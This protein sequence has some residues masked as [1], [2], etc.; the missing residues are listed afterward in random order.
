MFIGI[1][2][3]Y[4]A[5]LMVILD[6]FSLYVYLIPS[7]VCALIIGVSW[8]YFGKL[9]KKSFI[10][11]NLLPGL[12]FVVVGVVCKMV[13][14]SDYTYWY[15]HSL[16]HVFLGIGLSFSLPKRINLQDKMVYDNMYRI[17]TGSVKK[18]CGKTPVNSEFNMDLDEVDL[19][20]NGSVNNAANRST[21][22]S[23]R[24]P[25]SETEILDGIDVSKIK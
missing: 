18:N 15:M 21:Y 3:T 8:V 6:R 13:L 7:I 23:M 19:N 17:F 2:G 4:S 5:V 10:L 24:D 16:W 11:K 20:I 1:L 22:V 25:E 12:V 9:P 14:E